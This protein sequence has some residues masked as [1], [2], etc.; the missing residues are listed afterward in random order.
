MA[1]SKTRAKRAIKQDAGMVPV[2]QETLKLIPS[3]MSQSNLEDMRTPLVKKLL[4]AQMAVTKVKPYSG[5]I[6]GYFSSGAYLLNLLLSKGLGFPWTKIIHLTGA[7]GSGKAQPLYAKLSTPSGYIQMGDVEIGTVLHDTQGGTCRVTGVFPQGVKDVWEVVFSDGS[8]TQC[9]EEHLWRVKHLGGKNWQVKSLKDLKDNLQRA[10]G[11]YRWHIPVAAPIEYSD[12]SPELEL[13]P[14]FMGLLLG[15]CGMTGSTPIFSSSDIELVEAVADSLPSSLHV[16]YRSGVDYAISM[17]DTDYKKV[18]PYSRNALTEKLR[19]IGLWGKPTRLKFVPKAYQRASIANRLALLQG[20]LDTD[21]SPSKGRS[22]DWVTASPQLLEDVKGMVRSLGGRFREGA[23]KVVNGVVYHRASINFDAHI[24]PFRL[25][26][27]VALLGKDTPHHARVIK[28]V[29]YVGQEECQCI[30]VDS[31]DSCYLTDD[32]IVTHNTFLCLAAA[33]QVLDSGGTVF[34]YNQEDGWSWDFASLIGI[35][36]DDPNFVLFPPMLAEKCFDGISLML[37]GLVGDPS[38][39]L[40]VVDS[41]GG[42]L[43]IDRNDTEVEKGRKM[44]DIQKIAKDFCAKTVPYIPMTMAS[45]MVTNHVYVDISA[46]TAPGIPK[47]VRPTGGKAVPYRAFIELLLTA[48]AITK[49]S[50]GKVLHGG[51]RIKVTK[52]KGGIKD[53]RID[54][55]IFFRQ[56]KNRYFGVDDGMTSIQFLVAE[57]IWK[58]V[59]RNKKKVILTNYEPVSPEG[60]VGEAVYGSAPEL[61]DRMLAEG[62]K[63]F[64]KFTQA[65]VEAAF[66]KKFGLE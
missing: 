26:R 49:S 2:N 46:F 33:K 30:R 66:L 36:E 41:L 27:K 39:V 23:P 50:T 15:N 62:E 1:V 54:I 65:Q 44:G 7:E 35:R 24:V 12:S 60:E 25:Q 42:S 52:N 20:L 21:G 28:A 61:R 18:R 37:K 29:N 22:V 56:A 11:L 43:T 4:M 9:C 64:F 63:P 34:W 59:E 57:N 17:R 16:V 6:P 32:L 13:E 45:I 51:V 3:E 8:S 48:Q 53:L 47:P 5:R 19:K 58:I 14:Y 38:K 10:N 31:A 40:F 55:P